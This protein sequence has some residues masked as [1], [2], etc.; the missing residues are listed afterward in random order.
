MTALGRLV[1]RLTI[2]LLVLAAT[3][4]PATPSAAQHP[5]QVELPTLTLD[6]T[7]G[8]PGTP[9]NALATGYGS[10][11]TTGS[12]DVGPGSVAFLWDGVE[13]ATAGV[14]AADGTAGT[15]FQ[16]PDDAPIGPHTVTSQCVGDETLPQEETFDVIEPTVTPVVVPSVLGRT[17][18]E[19]TKILRGA[20][21]V[22][23]VIT[24][25]GNQVEDQ[26]PDAGVEV[27]PGTPVDLQLTSEEPDVVVVPDVVEM[28]AEEAEATIV[29]AGLR[30]GRLS[31]EGGIVQSQSPAAG[32]EVE[33]LAVVDLVMVAEPDEEVVVPDLVGKEVADAQA[34]LLAGKLEL[35]LVTGSG[36]VVR[37]QDPPAGERALAGSS[38]NISVESSIEPVALATVPDLVGLT[39]PDA[40]QAC[41]DVGLVL[42]DTPSTESE[43]SSQQ[44]VAGLLVPVGSTVTVAFP[45]PTDRTRIAVGVGLLVLLVAAAA[46][47]TVAVRRHRERLWVR[48]HVDLAPDPGPLAPAVPVDTEDPD[49]VGRHVVQL[50]P[51][52]EAESPVVVEEWRDDH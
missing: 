49:R 27:D 22:V 24:G 39:V 15:Q 4:G 48:S 30:L 52:A 33:P 35:G 50:A 8:T 10:C 28:S 42:G 25:E 5:T 20:E 14:V 37:A 17:P 40:R 32:S 44:P 41:E 23:G 11:P 12:D 9:V 38:V 3:A 19:A 7:E 34:A 2:V 51:H 47:A 29:D 43:I 31:G 36:D 16:V 1:W 46:A 26:D 18:A 45:E 13:V 6:P 21:L